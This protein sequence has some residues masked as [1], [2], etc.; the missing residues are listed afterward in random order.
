[1]FC[2]KCGNTIVEDSEFC[3]KCGTKVVQATEAS[4]QAE[5][6]TVE[7]RPT[8]QQVPPNNAA[9][10]KKTGG[11]RSVVRVGRNIL[12]GF[13][14]LLALF[15]FLGL[16]GLIIGAVIVGIL[17]LIGWRMSMAEKRKEEDK[18]K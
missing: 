3:H 11:L 6:T 13:A 9:A 12:V 2:H 15:S 4:E 8:A 5:P 17:I 7:T 18:A 10:P 16:V 1:M 14:I